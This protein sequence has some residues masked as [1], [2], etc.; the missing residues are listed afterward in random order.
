M[1]TANQR[2]FGNTV[3]VVL[4]CVVKSCSV[5]LSKA[6][7]SRWITKLSLTWYAGA[8]RRFSIVL[9]TRRC[10]VLMLSGAKLHYGGNDLPTRVRF[11][12]STTGR[13]ILESSLAED[14][15]GAFVCYGRRKLG[16]I[17]HKKKVE[18]VMLSGVMLS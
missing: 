18:K 4:G 17:F 3:L 14:G 1:E 16:L 2:S 8:R 11:C 6:A 15:C 13:L 7:T 9:I 10:V 5:L 12:N